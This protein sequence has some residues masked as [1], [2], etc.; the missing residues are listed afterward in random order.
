MG[1]AFAVRPMK[2][3]LRFFR[4][5][6]FNLFHRPRNRRGLANRLTVV[7]A[8]VVAG[9]LPF[10]IEGSGQAVEEVASAQFVA[11]L[12]E[13]YENRAILSVLKDD[14][15]ASAEQIEDL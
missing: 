10:L 1:G 14:P 7:V 15:N 9:F 13:L 3:V 4:D 12:V 8:A 11:A 6:Q 5:I 2:S